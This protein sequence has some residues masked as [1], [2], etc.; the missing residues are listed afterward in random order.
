[1][2]PS[3]YALLVGV[4][5]VEAALHQELS[6]HLQSSEQGPHREMMLFSS[7]FPSMQILV[8][9][10]ILALAVLLLSTRADA[11]VPAVPCLRDPFGIL[12][13]PRCPGGGFRKLNVAEQGLPVTQSTLWRRRSTGS[14]AGG[15]LNARKKAAYKAGGASGGGGGFGKKRSVSKDAGGEEKVF[16][17]GGGGEEDVFDLGGGMDVADLMK[18]LEEEGGIDKLESMGIEVHSLKDMHRERKERERESKLTRST[19]QST[20]SWPCHKIRLQNVCFI[21]Q[22]ATPCRLWM[23]WR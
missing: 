2:H 5:G 13:G 8:R 18:M 16:G 6:R 23:R 12:F 17:G 22:G 1:L 7:T 4:E 10:G 9:P 11:L 20:R 19:H 14:A 3:P 21:E 15:A